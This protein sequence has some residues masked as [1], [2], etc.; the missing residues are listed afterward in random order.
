M[1]VFSFINKIFKI[2]LDN[3]N[4]FKKSYEVGN[5]VACN[6]QLSETILKKKCKGNRMFKKNVITF[7]HRAFRF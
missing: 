3:S 2:F 6:K 1:T 4:Y 5:L 7:V